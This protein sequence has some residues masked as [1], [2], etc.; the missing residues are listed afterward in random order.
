MLALQ[1]ANG[2]AQTAHVKHGNRG[3]SGRACH[4]YSSF[5]IHDTAHKGMQ[6]Q[7]EIGEPPHEDDKTNRNRGWARCGDVVGVSRP[8]PS[9]DSDRD[10]TGHWLSRIPT[11]LTLLDSLY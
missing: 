3:S 5:P 1:A 4:V 11:G 10:G 2:Y 8:I 6:P 7:S 9:G